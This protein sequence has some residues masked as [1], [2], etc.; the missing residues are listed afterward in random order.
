MNLGVANNKHIE[1][2]AYEIDVNYLGVIRLNNI[3]MDKLKSRKEA[4]FINITSNFC[5]IPSLIEATYSSSKVALAFYTVSLLEHLKIA[6]STVKVFD[7]IPP[8]V[9]TEMT[10]ERN[11]K[12]ISTE[13]FV[14]G[15]IKGL[16]KNQNLIRVGDAKI[17]DFI[18]RLF[19]KTA[20]RPINPKKANEIL[21]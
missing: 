9:A 14:K 6:G 2:A 7:L 8:H 3:F 10:S 20:F 5:I 21:E 11:D 1:N 12:K 17:V 13:E 19:P 16:T 15:L 4:A 18:K